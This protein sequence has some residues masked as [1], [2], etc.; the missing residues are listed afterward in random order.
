[1]ASYA[2][3]RKS[4]TDF[5][6]QVSN[7]VDRYTRTSWRNLRI[8]TLLTANG[9]T[10]IDMLF[11]YKNIIFIVEAK[12]VSSIVGGYSDRYW[13][14]IGSKGTNSEITEYSALSVLTQNNI[15]MKAFKELFYA[16]YKEWPLVV[17]VIVVP[18]SCKVSEDIA[19]TIHSL[20]SL[21]VFL[22]SAADWD[23]ECTVQRRVA[24][25]F[26]GHGQLI[27]RPDFETGSNGG[28]Q[29]ICRK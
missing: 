29:K 28:R 12:N 4:G 27:Q 22:A 21:D 13:R 10:E 11:C 5:E 26:A 23:I 7:I 1:M 6:N 14:F 8:E 24:A 9:F 25:I 18:N 20:S 17:P 16:F 3:T 19:S 15:H 2:Q